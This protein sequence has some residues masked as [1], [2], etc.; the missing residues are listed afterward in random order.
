[1]VVGKELS[2]FYRQKL[3]IALVEIFGGR[4]SNIDL[5]KYLFLFTHLCQQE[6]SYE[7]V[8]YK[9]GC[10]SFQSYADRRRLINAGAMKQVDNW[11]IEHPPPTLKLPS[12][13][14]Q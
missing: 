5:Q 9:Y 8:P 7:F 2:L 1:M 13:H 11:E 14:P 3:L 12:N 6:K 4:L 10:F